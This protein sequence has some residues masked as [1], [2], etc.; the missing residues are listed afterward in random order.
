MVNYREH[1]RKKKITLATRP[2]GKGQSARVDNILASMSLPEINSLDLLRVQR[3]FTSGKKNTVNAFCPTSC[4]NCYHDLSRKWN[5]FMSFSISVEYP[6]DV[7]SELKPFEKFIAVLKTPTGLKLD[8]AERARV[9]GDNCISHPTTINVQLRVKRHVLRCKIFNRRQ[10]ASQLTHSPKDLIILFPVA[11]GVLG[12]N[13]RLQVKV[14][15]VTS[16]QNTGPSEQN[17]M[18]KNTRRTK[19]QIRQLNP[20]L[21]NRVH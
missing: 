15:V 7:P 8:F 12:A 3:A 9:A 16:L 6:Y 20:Q 10:F 2:T 11:Y 1:N 18:V 21:Y 13:L 5:I 4:F 19:N 17:F 14:N